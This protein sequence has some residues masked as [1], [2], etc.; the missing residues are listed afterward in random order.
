MNKIKVLN[1]EV[2]KEIVGRYDLDQFWTNKFKV[3]IIP[4]IFYFYYFFTLK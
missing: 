1:V 2:E 3:R 4:N